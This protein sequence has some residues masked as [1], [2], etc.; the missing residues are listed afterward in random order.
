MWSSGKSEKLDFSTTLDKGMH[1]LIVKG[2]EKC[3]DGST[4]WG[5][6]VNNGEWED[7]TIDNLDKHC[8]NAPPAEPTEPTEKVGRIRTLVIT[9]V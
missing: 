8:A 9:T 2:G 3:C 4:K 1:V 5:L 6:Q 7:F